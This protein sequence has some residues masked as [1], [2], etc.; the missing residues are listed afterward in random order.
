MADENKIAQFCSEFILELKSNG[1]DNAIS[2]LNKLIQ[3]EKQVGNNLQ[4][5]I[6]KYGGV[7]KAIKQLTKSYKVK[8]SIVDKNLNT[9]DKKVKK[10]TKTYGS[11]SSVVD[12]IKSG[13]KNIVMPASFGYALKSADQYNKTMLSLSSSVSRLG[14][15]LVSLENNLTRIGRVTSLTRSETNKLFDDFQAGM[16]VIST[17]DFENIM[18][19]MHSIVGANVE[20]M[21]KLQGSLVEVSQQ[22]PVLSQSLAKLANQQHKMSQAD[23]N[24]IKDK[25]R[26]LYFIGKISDAQYRQ[27]AT[28]VNGNEQINSSDKKRKK[29]MEEQ[30]AAMNKFRR[31]IESV[32]LM[33]GQSLLPF[34]TK[35]A[36]II[37]VWKNGT[38]SFKKDL[39]WIVGTFGVFK[40]AK[41]VFSLSSVGMA[42]GGGIGGLIGRAVGG[43]GTNVYI[44]GIAPGVI[45]GGGTS[46]L[47]RAGRKGTVM[48]EGS[49][50][51]RSRVGGMVKRG[52]MGAGLSVGSQMLKG[53]ST[54]LESQGNIKGAAVAGLGSSAMSI[55]SMA[56]MGS[57]L[58]PVGAVVGA[59]AG[60][61]LE[62][63]NVTKGFSGLFGETSGKT[64]QDF[65]QFVLDDMS[66]INKNR[67]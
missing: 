10:L 34:M 55:G 65:H 64:K 14:V 32:S 13:L 30:V 49:T 60:L 22:Y 18:K 44:T 61:V 27:L 42:K 19:R 62:I 1:V 3:V 54:S 66:T 16:R 9:E 38:R 25:I 33:V 23:K 52:L 43:K 41:S 4:D 51:A 58:G 40:I 46:L 35:I 26:Q 45:G 7:K 59:L 20:A 29:D 53:Y 24:S 48:T 5:I 63:G 56:M 12:E 11:L 57:M 6:R 21:G 39:A 47:G 31:Q 36:D 50:K 15:G 2:E 37:T 67:T 8:S 28:Y 17:G